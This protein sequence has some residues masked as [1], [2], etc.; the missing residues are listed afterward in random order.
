MRAT[1]EKKRLTLKV[2]NNGIYCEGPGELTFKPERFLKTMA[3]LNVPE[4]EYVLEYA[5]YKELI[6]KVKE[7]QA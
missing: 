1:K 3:S 5:T 2:T 4:G 6:A 7:L